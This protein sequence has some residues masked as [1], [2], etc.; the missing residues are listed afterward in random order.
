[1]SWAQFEEKEYELAANIE[2]AA[3]PS[4]WGPVFSSGQVL[5]AIVGYDAAADPSPTH[6]LWQILNAPRP[7]GIVLVPAHW[8]PGSR[9]PAS[10]LPSSLVSLIV[11]YKRPERMVGPTARQWKSWGE[12]YFRF[13][14]DPGQQ[15][16]LLRLEQQ[17]RQYAV[18][19][20]A[21]P[22]FWQRGH[23]EAALLR[24]SILTESGFVGPDVMAG[25]RVW[26]YVQ[27]GIGGRAN[28][29]RTRRT[30]E[31]LS[32]LRLRVSEPTKAT[33]RQIEK[34]DDLFTHLK[35]LG[36]AARD[37]QPG[38][39]VTLLRWQ[40]ILDREELS[41]SKQQRQA[42]IDLASLTSLLHARGGNWY[43]LSR[44]S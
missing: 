42:V 33:G 37:R 41:L 28:P 10:R 38:L 25:H 44:S 16:V 22:A 8:A 4:G 31:G 7:S 14:I 24:R 6:P 21:G 15:S 3:S 30:F 11:Q 9:P 34:P 27:P 43:L 12:P 23:F 5:E 29:S 17:L 32:D 1:V 20:Y 36:D 26:S 18:V 39:R 40:R 13:T 35:R 19:R 2:L